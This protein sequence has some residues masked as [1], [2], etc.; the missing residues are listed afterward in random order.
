MK[1]ERGMQAVMTSRSGS[2]ELCGQKRRSNL[3]ERLPDGHDSQELV[4][5]VG[6]ESRGSTENTQLLTCSPRESARSG[7]FPGISLIKI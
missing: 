1:T 6:G 7:W 4:G 2:Q 3:G 5:W